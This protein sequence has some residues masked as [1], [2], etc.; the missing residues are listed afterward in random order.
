MHKVANIFR[1]HRD[2]SKSS[3]VQDTKSRESVL[4]VAKAWKCEY[5]VDVVVA[6]GG[7]PCKIAKSG[8]ENREKW[9]R[10]CNNS[11]IAV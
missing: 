6:S 3:R 11:R 5:M 10:K 1:E 7:L 8:R 2:N 9:S 4:E